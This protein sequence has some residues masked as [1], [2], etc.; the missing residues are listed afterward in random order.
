MRNGDWSE[1][2]VVRGDFQYAGV[3]REIGGDERI[4]R[5]NA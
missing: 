2:S 3:I 1:A 4:G 5:G